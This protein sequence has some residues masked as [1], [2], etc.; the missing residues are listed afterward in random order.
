[1]AHPGMTIWVDTPKFLKKAP[2]GGGTGRGLSCPVALA[3]VQQKWIPVLRSE[4]AL[5][6]SA[7]SNGKPVNT[8]PEN[9][10]APGQF[11]QAN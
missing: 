5:W 11:L 9:A 4:H 3:R 6:N 1:M 10:P 7:F 8:L 2:P